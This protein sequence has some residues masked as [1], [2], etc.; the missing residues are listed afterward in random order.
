[1]IYF[2]TVITVVD[3]LFISSIIQ[4][5][6]YKII[7]LILLQVSAGNGS[8]VATVAML[9]DMNSP[10][11]NMIGNALEVAETI[12]CLHGEGP[13]DVT[14][15]VTRLGKLSLYVHILTFYLL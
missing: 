10:L 3:K 14:D 9:T 4:L 6:G 8:G 15:L 5:T 1:M 11:G 12:Y 2:Y 13:Q 7:L